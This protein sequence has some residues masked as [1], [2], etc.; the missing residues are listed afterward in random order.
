LDSG[1]L[2]AL[3]FA[4]S[5]A[6][7]FGLN[8]HI[9]NRA[10]DD[11]DPLTGALYSVTATAGMFWLFSPFFIDW[12]WFGTRTAL[13][14]AAV[15]L[16]FPAFG[17]RLQIASI[18]IVGP[19]ITAACG[20]FTPL[21]AILPAVVFLG[22]SFGLQ[23]S[24]GLMLLTSSLVFAALGRGKIK[25]N[26][27]LWALLLPLAASFV[28]GLA[29]PIT[30]FG[31]AEIPS[32]YFATMLMATVSVGTLLVIR[33]LSTPRQK[34]SSGLSKSGKQRFLFSGIIN[35]FGI[36]SVNMALSFGDVS[37]VAPFLATS[38]LF[39][40]ALG[41]WVFR[42]EVLGWHHLAIVAVAIAGA[43]LVITR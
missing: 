19:A 36:L 6:V 33:T 10:L 5:A 2:I 7:L 25:R 43:V 35:G 41:A 13:I 30:K 28:R 23:A 22:E 42:R 17:Q 34:A 26:W 18:V 20:S 1:T 27:P 14:F 21:F 29:Q 9:Q 40:L 24:F 4:L 15:G 32:P 8:P 16:I 38:P 11:T 12:A 31:F 39:T 3:L 37:V